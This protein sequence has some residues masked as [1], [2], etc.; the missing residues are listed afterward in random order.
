M[1]E[2]EKKI[3]DFIIEKERVSLKEL[4]EEFNISKRTLYYDIKSVNYE[5]AGIGRIENLDHKFT[6]SGSLTSLLSEDLRNKDK[7]IL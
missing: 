6:Y 1:K 5:L 7:F 4:L 3:L 2:R